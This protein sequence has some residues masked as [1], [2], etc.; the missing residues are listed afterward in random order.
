M[1]KGEVEGEGWVRVTGRVRVRGRGGG[2][3]WVEA[4]AYLSGTGCGI[5]L[6]VGK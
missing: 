1:G 6:K 5:S 3:W 2:R 4:R